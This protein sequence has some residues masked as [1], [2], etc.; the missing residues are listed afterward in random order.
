MRPRVLCVLLLAAVLVVVLGGVA[1]GAII[2]DTTTAY[3]SSADCWAC[4]K[5]VPGPAVSKVD[6]SVSK[7]DYAKCA[8]CHAAINPT[9]QHWH[10]SHTPCWGCHSA[11]T[12]YQPNNFPWG[13]TYYS[14]WQ[15]AYG[16]FKYADSL[17]KTPQTLHQAH[18]G[19]NW[20]DSLVFAN[21]A[22]CQPCHEPVSCS[23][24]HGDVVAHT[25]HAVTGYPA[26]TYLQANGTAAVT[27][28]STC[29]N[30][31]CHD[32]AKGATAAFK[33]ACSSC[34]PTRMTYHGYGTGN[35]LAADSTEG[36]VAC[37]SC[38][39][40]ELA[41]VHLDPTASGTSCAK[42]HP[43]P[44]Q[45]LGIW[46]RSCVGGGC[47]TVT[48]TRPM[49]SRTATAHAVAPSNTECLNCHPG[50]ELGSVH[51][52]AVS[53][54]TAAKSCLVCHS[55]TAKPATG[56]CTVCH[57]TFAV[58]YNL[59]RHN[60]ATV[61]CSGTGCHNTP[62]LMD[63][64]TQRNAAFN[65]QGC[66]KSVR[67]D[68]QY[69]IKNHLTGC[70]DCHSSIYQ[71]S[72]HRSIHGANP[73]LRDQITGAPNYAY[74]TGSAG[75]AKTTDCAGCH[76]SNIVDEHV[77]LYLAG[78]WVTFP[79]KDSSGVLY[80]CDTCHGATAPANVKAAIA[81]TGITACEN[82]HAVHGPI[83]AVHTSTFVDAAPLACADCHS[84][85]L[86]VVH[87]GTYKSTVGLSGCDVCHALYTGTS[88]AVA[89]TTVE[90]AISVTN[91]TKCSACHGTYHGSMTA[92]H[93]NTTMTAECTQAGCHSASLPTEHDKYLQRYPAYKSSCVLCH[94]N[95]TPTRI[96]WATATADCRSCHTPHGD[97]TLIHTAKASA[98]CTACH[99]TGDVRQLH[100]TSAAVSCAVCHNAPAGRI[101]WA[102]ATVEC[103]SC[104]GGKSPVDPNHYPVTAHSASAETAC[105]Q[106]HYT[107]MKTEH[108]LTTV[109]P[110][111]TCV[112]CHET[113]VD[114]F[115]VAWNKTCATCHAIKHADQGTRHVST[116][117]GCGG[118]G[119]HVLADVA[120]IHNKPLGPGCA[121]CH[122]SPAV[123]ATTTNCTDAGCHASIGPNHHEAHNS[124]LVNTG[125]CQGC[126][127]MY[128]DDE[129]AALGF[130][131]A[132]CHDS[133]SATVKGAIAAKDLRCK[134]CHPAM[135]VKQD[136]EFNPTLAGGHRVRADLPGMRSSFTVNGSTYTWALPS[137]ATFLKT[138]W[139]TSSVMTC[140]DCHSYSGATGP[141]GATMKVNVDPAYPNP[142]RV[143]TGLETSTAQLSK[144]SPTGMSMTKSGTARAGV[145][146]EKCHDLYNG[147]S[148]SNV[149]HAEHDDRG[150]E[151]AYCNQC[152]IGIPHGW[153]RPRLLG[154]VTDAAPYA[155]WAGTG[156]S[157]GGLSRVSIKNY[158]P[159]AWSKADC[160]AACSPERH[161]VSGTSWPAGTGTAPVP[162]TGTIT[163]AVTGPSGGITGATVSVAGKTATAGS[164]GTY[165]MADVA[166][167]TYTMTVSATGYTTWSGSVTVSA[168]TTTTTN[169]TMTVVAPTSTNLART[170]TATASSRDSD[171]TN[172]A[173]AIDGSTGTYWR[174]YGHSTEWLAIDLGSAKTL[175]KIVV[176][177]SGSS[178]A[179]SFRVETS[180]DGANWTSRYSTSSGYGG[181][182]T[183][184]LSPVGARYARVYCTYAN[185]Y[186]YRVNEFEV[187]G[188]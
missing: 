79:R 21:S 107:D 72:G 114:T 160:G 145:I 151:G 140:A 111:V 52:N 64:H 184:T 159:Y 133:T 181:V 85:D 53:K 67:T 148:W 31:A 103:S 183:I 27:A 172:A 128:L 7:V 138:G 38:H 166:A 182:N 137:V 125:G 35:H 99:E 70:G 17:S 105:G 121:A 76:T 131:C 1:Y 188:Y 26:V 81:G 124:T 77:G 161:P 3:A 59:T 90:N 155:T 104:H 123:R 92:K 127:S 9:T 178:Y 40:L 118:T 167:G 30:S 83:T 113:K 170:G 51:V 58:H 42:C 10:A 115:T 12:S 32:P 136:Y 157:N 98:A 95:A 108:F 91:S 4:H 102:T 153:S 180:S 187:W 43:Q 186:D 174:S 69:A 88:G 141:H 49:H 39:S 185:D 16:T 63:V 130:T 71:V 18:A 57:F 147:S 93:T 164:G 162:T 117:A 61:T 48:S 139:T 175:T 28:S 168:G 122:V 142:Y 116:T 177:W 33:P 101:D 13:A 41:T 97:I 171:S 37:S 74:Y 65:C 54:T 109:S 120:A 5:A 6:F 146:C 25:N 19:G 163:G 20:V 129:H 14:L 60:S 176:N 45:S 82:C 135:H 55:A 89:G 15:T 46:N 110:A 112:A 143:T 84:P 24:C 132:T 126:H 78:S 94:K 11:T 73:P 2:V 80:S 96:N 150:A 100:G 68:V 144:S 149:A 23:A 179:K 56:D 50:T 8:T 119:C 29:V 169:I 173:K 34:H 106:C 66:H 165:S 75:A 44:R 87:G 86:T 62:G 158:T 47:H 154:Y 134:T 36:G 156:R 152:H 22:N